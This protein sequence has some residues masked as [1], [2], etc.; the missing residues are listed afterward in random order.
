MIIFAVVVFSCASFDQQ[1]QFTKKLES[2]AFVA[3][4]YGSSTKTLSINHPDG[5]HISWMGFVQSNDYDYFKVTKVQVGSETIVEDGEEIAGQTYTASPNAVIKDVTIAA[6]SSDSTD[7]AD[8]AIS[9]VGSDDFKL[10]IQY[11]PLQAIQAENEPHEAYLLINYDA[12]KLGSLRL[13]LAGYTQGMKEDKCTQAVSTMDVIAYSVVGSAFDLYFCG[14]EVANVGQDNT[15]KDTSDPDYHGA[16]T[17]LETIPLTDNV[18][19]F[20]QVDAETVCVLSEPDPT[21]PDFVLPIPEGLAPIQTMDISMADGSYA[22][23]TLDESGNIL[24]DE[25]IQIDALVTLSGL[26][27]SSEGFT[28]EELVTSDCPDFGAI[29]GSGAFGDDAL[30]LVLTGRTLSDMNTEAYN[31]VDSLMVGVIE[32]ER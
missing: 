10:T 16:S 20:Y 15:T 12:P 8:G 26:S 11:S 28:A 30:T 2:S 18:I 9:V 23:C 17:N 14:A 25:N 6:S 21:F 1:D 32:L 5:G 29:S 24:C 31:I 7:Y 22:E 4:L 19:T 13:K 27:L 3:E